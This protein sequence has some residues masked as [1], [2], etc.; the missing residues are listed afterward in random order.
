L[1]GSYPRLRPP[2][3]LTG[4]RNPKGMRQQGV[5]HTARIHPPVKMLAAF[6]SFS[7]GRRGLPTFLARCEALRSP[8]RSDVNGVEGGPESRSEFHGVI[9]RPEVDEE[10]AGFVIEHV[11]VDRRDLN[12]VVAQGFDE[13][14]HLAR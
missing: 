8:F 7:A 9:V 13:G 14:V 3:I 2:L 1:P 5:W 11:I 10:G 12:A 6:L 4:L